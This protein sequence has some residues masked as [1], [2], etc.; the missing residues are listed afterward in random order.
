[1]TLRLNQRALRASTALACVAA[2]AIS[3]AAAGAKSPHA[4]TVT[5]Q[6]NGQVTF[7]PPGTTDPDYCSV[8]GAP[9][10]KPSKASTAHKRVRRAHP[11]AHA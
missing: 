3:P 10:P 2:L 4:P 8:V 5:P 1:M 11:K 7:C 6:H 9:A